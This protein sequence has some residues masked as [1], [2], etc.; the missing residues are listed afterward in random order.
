M[1]SLFGRTSGNDAGY[2]RRGR[3]PS[4]VRYGVRRPQRHGP[5]ASGQRRRVRRN[6]FASFV[7]TTIESYD[8]L[9]YG[10]SSALV[11]P[12]V[13]FPDLGGAAGTVAAL[14]TFSVAF[15]LRPLG[16]VV[17]GHLGDRFGRK[18]TLIL[19]LLLMG[20]PSLVVGLLP[21]AGVL[22]VAAPILLVALRGMQGL[23]IG[24]EWGGAALLT[25]EYAPP[26]RRG[27]YTGFT[28]LA[29]GVA[30][31]LS[32]ATFLISGLLMS[33][34]AFLA[35]GWR[36][37]FVLGAVLVAVGLYVRLRVVEN[38]ALRTLTSS[39]AF[40][41]APLREVVQLHRKELL[42]G[43]GALCSAFA[44]GYVASV[45]LTRYGTDVV[46]LSRTTMLGLGVIGGL[47]LAASALS[48]AYASDRYGRRPV[49]LVGSVFTI[50]CGLVVFLL[51]NTGQVL[52]VAVGVC[53]LQA[54]GGVCLGPAAAVLPEL[55]AT[56]YRYTGAGLS[57]N[58]AA[59]A[60][61]GVPLVLAAVLEQS[62][63]S[64]AV[65]VMLASLGLL[66]ALSA[67]FLPETVNRRLF[68]TTA[69]AAQPARHAS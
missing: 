48:A 5:H 9:V 3:A 33:Q 30:V 18:R 58:L 34:A 60:G 63:G 51:I 44:T 23:A 64:Y 53:L 55:F 10:V 39:Q 40:R 12:E 69:D 52:L 13:F 54:S 21:G 8:F 14:T 31:A 17:F 41:P 61:G 50:G 15:I 68:D 26:S 2:R 38:P 37:P 65:G 66:S 42:L 6:A 29:P 57:Y 36:I 28:Q 11:F 35:W 67:S 32:S 47:V 24:G 27:W 43:G 4:R 16:S 7:G 62:V 1:V 46:G 22:G 20:V 49:L 45:F 59:A 25:A 19:T 56:C